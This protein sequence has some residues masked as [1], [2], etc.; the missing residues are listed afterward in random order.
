MDRTDFIKNID[1]N[2]LSAVI[3]NFFDEIMILYNLIGGR[4]DLKVQVD[5]SAT[6]ATFTLVMDN[7]SDAKELYSKLNGMDFSIY[8][9][10]FAIAMNINNE[11]IS[12]TITQI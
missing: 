3:A 10:T 4:Q 5:E 11:S 12:T 6:T 2:D 8:G 1:S 7:D 9:I